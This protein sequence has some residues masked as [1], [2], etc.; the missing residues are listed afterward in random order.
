MTSRDKIRYISEI[1]EGEVGPLFVVY[2][3]QAPDQLFQGTS[4]S[5]AWKKV[6]LRL[7]DLREKAGMSR[8]VASISGE[9]VSSTSFAGPEMYG[10]SNPKVIAA[11]ERLPGVSECHGYI[12]ISFEEE[13][14]QGDAG[15]N[16]SDFDLEDDMDEEDD[17]T[18]SLSD[19]LELESDAEEQNV[20]VS[21]NTSKKRNATNLRVRCHSL[22][23]G[24]EADDTLMWDRSV[25]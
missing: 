22:S 25:C 3:E 2:P 8:T 4:A 9:C 12:P 1:R 6:L 10:L 18:P 15:T 24:Y 5:G 11:I 20:D 14:P 16:E 17:E 7:N 13:I 19:S 21:K 23:G